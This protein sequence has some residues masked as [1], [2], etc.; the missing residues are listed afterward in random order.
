MLLLTQSFT[1]MLK[2]VGPAVVALL[3]STAVL[4]MVSKSIPQLNIFNVGL[5]SNMVVMFLAVFLTLGGCLWLF[6]NDVEQTTTI[7]QQ[8]L[9]L[10]GSRP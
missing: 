2:A 7:I 3:I 8:S 9:E 10:T 6:V 4:G 1:L 5:S